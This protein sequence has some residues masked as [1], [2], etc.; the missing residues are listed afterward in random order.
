MV[1]QRSPK[2]PFNRRALAHQALRASAAVRAEAGLDQTG[3]ICI[4]GLCEKMGIRVR[5][6]N[7]NMEGMYQRGTPPR[8]H[9]SALRPLPRRAYNCAHELGHHIFGHGSSID[10]LREESKESPLEDPKEF[11]ADVFGGFILMP[12]LGIRR[13]FATRGWTPEAAT[14]LQLFMIACDFGVGFKTLITHLSAGV[15]MMPRGRAAAIGRIPLRELRAEILGFSTTESLT[16]ADCR[17]TAPTIDVEVNMLL[18]LPPGTKTRGTMLALE[19]NL[20]VGSLYRA[21]RPGIAQAESRVSGWST[22]VRVAPQ[23]YIGLAQYRHLE[24][25]SDE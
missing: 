6:N 25:D 7:I 14:P 4:Y 3:P 5:F 16:I 22:F 2:L 17:R 21:V 23:A 19:R 10:Q 9:L 20:A 11:L 15:N 18:L 8:I 12:V 24:D 1:M 13:A